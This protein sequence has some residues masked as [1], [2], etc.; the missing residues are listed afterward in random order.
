MIIAIIMIVVIPLLINEI[1]KADTVYVTKWDANDVLQ[2]Y[3]SV[4]SFCGTVALGM[5]T[6]KLSSQANKI[7]ERLLS[8]ELSDKKPCLIPTNVFWDLKVGNS[9]NK[10]VNFDPS[11]G[12]DNIT[13]TL[14][15]NPSQEHRSFHPIAA[16]CFKFENVGKG[17]I[18][19]LRFIKAEYKLFEDAC[20]ESRNGASY[21]GNCL[22]RENDT[23]KIIFLFYQ[24]I[25]ND[26]TDE[27]IK[28]DVNS[29]NLMPYI[30][31]KI[32][33]K[34]LDGLTFIEHLRLDTDFKQEEKKKNCNCTRTI[35]I[36]EC[37]VKQ[38]EKKD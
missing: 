38:L 2:Y 34:T 7:N 36:T 5:V 8:L 10:Y 15:I 30:D 27:L 11:L 23:K 17:M 28:I 22:F 35:I 20:I 4:L 16:S 18:T 33:I 29:S 31:L 3:G 32:E 26:V 13:V 19:S 14:Y 9:L 37:S 24:D 1:Y 25:K 12:K 21:V 6:I